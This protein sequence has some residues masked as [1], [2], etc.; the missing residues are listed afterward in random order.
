MSITVMSY[1][2]NMS[3]PMSWKAALY[4]LADWADDDGRNIFPAMAT[5]GRTIGENSD[6]EE[7]LRKRGQRWIKQF[8]DAGILEVDKGSVGGRG[9]TVRY[10]LNVELMAEQAAQN[11]DTAV[12]V[13]EKST[14]VR[15]DV[16]R[17]RAV[18]QNRDRAVSH[19]PSV[20]VRDYDLV[21]TPDRPCPRYTPDQFVRDFNNIVASPH[22]PNIPFVKTVSERRRKKIR[23]RLEEQPHAEY[24]TD[25]ESGVFWLIRNNRF[26]R[27][28]KTNWHVKLDWLIEN[29]DNHTKIAEGNF[30]RDHVAKARPSPEPPKQEAEPTE[31]E[32]EASR[33]AFREAAEERGLLA[34]A[35]GGE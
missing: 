22:C 10:R 24:W 13:Y 17:D 3:L 23:K 18:S 15:N 20:S 30:A 2:K 11:R 14:T 25:R 19:D 32:R 5:Y 28:D 4:P 21:L 35:G 34:A 9:K 16:N 1:V 26:L 12:T 27:G 6:N 33:R 29:T 7:T 8:I 31:E